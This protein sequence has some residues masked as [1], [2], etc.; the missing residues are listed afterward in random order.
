[1]SKF[2]GLKLLKEESGP[3]TP[4]SEPPK[5]EVPAKNPRPIGKRQNPEYQQISAY[6]RRDLYDEIRKQLIGRQED[7]SDLLESWMKN[8]LGPKN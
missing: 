7:F 4:P 6:V 3:R 8:W 1:M 2:D 5:P